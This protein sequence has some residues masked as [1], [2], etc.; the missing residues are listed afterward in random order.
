[1][2]KVVPISDGSWG[3]HWSP[4]N[5]IEAHKAVR[6]SGKYTF[7][8]CRIPVPTAIRYDRLQEALGD[9]ATPKEVRTLSL[10]EF[11][12]PINCNPSFGIKKVQKN[13]SSAMG[14]KEEV[15]GYVEKGVQSQAILGPLGS[16]LLKTFV[17]IH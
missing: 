17:I 2:N 14:F 10:L 13:H 3:V 4:E 5:F 8:G 11:G 1:M 6:E 12:M 16:L 7:E 15:S 9:T